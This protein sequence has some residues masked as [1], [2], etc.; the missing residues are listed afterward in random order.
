MVIYSL[1]ETYMQPLMKKD[2]ISSGPAVSL[3]FN[4]LAALRMAFS[5]I[6]GGHASEYFYCEKK[7]SE[8]FYFKNIGGMDVK[9]SPSL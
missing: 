2:E 9:V 1:S 4:F 5:L 6:F 3:S 7:V 8:Y